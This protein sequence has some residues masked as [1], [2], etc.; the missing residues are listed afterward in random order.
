DA[1]REE[2]KFETAI[3]YYQQGVDIAKEL[4]NRNGESYALFKLGNAYL[5]LR[6]FLE[7]RKYYQQCLEIYQEL[8]N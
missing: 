5:N 3:N 6:Q 2:R 8:D 7:A 1:Y 4:K